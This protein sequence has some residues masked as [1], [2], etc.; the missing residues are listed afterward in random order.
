MN[1][2]PSSDQLAAIE[3][4]NRIGAII[5]PAIH[6]TIRGLLVSCPGVP[7]GTVLNIIAYEAA[8]FMGQAL[9][10]D[11]AALAAVR[12]GISAA[13]EE[14]MRK[15][16]LLQSSNW[17][18]PAGEILDWGCGSGIAARAFLDYFGCGEVTH[19]RLWDRSAAAMAFAARRAGEKYPALAV[20]TGLGQSPSLVLVRYVAARSLVTVIGVPL[21]QPR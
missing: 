3:A 1:Q 17:Q 4:M 6:T 20:S 12:K 19:L 5:R 15:A 16:P 13:F 10:G 7:P 14:G 18:P 2:Q 8:N 11:L 21:V 9:Q